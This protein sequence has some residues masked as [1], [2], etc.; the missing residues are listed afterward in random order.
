MT[1]GGR[2]R[3]PKKNGR[4]RVAIDD[5]LKARLAVERFSGAY[6]N[7]GALARSYG[8]AT[9]VVSRAIG[10]AFREGMVEVR[11]VPLDPKYRTPNRLTDVE[12]ALRRRYPCLR[13][14]IV[15]DADERVR[16]DVLH[17][18]IGHGLAPYFADTM[19]WEPVRALVG[20]G[21]CIFHMADWLCKLDLR[22][23]ANDVTLISACGDSYPYHDERKDQR[24]N[25]CLDA[26]ANA[27]LLSQAFQDTALVGQ[28]SRHVFIQESDQGWRNEYY[29]GFW[30]PPPTLGILGVGILNTH[31]QL[32]LLTDP[33][34]RGAFPP[35]TIPDQVSRNIRELY[36]IWSNTGS[37]A[38]QDVVAEIGMHLFYVPDSSGTRKP[39]EI[40]RMSRLI[41]GINERLFAPSITD[42]AAVKSLVLV[43][44]G[45][46]KVRA[47]HHLLSLASGLAEDLSGPLTPSLRV[48]C[49]D[50][51]T[52][53]LLLA[54]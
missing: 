40:Q 4:R 3:V 1:N 54:I 21:R 28:T 15:V 25:I 24:K 6:D 48:L 49:T 47:M 37:S 43:G 7:I 46:T 17:E 51:G 22:L 53:R 10:S 26:D 33:A 38:V 52:A 11:R 32:I 9:A 44:G 45:S 36:D 35:I 31:H 50:G 41:A 27:Q 42:L 23:K 14:A 12:F 34:T 30:A 29:Q 13:T 16:Q 39:S 20:S 8:R 18:R 5:E 2:K 19:I